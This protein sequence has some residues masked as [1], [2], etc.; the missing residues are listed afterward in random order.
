MKLVGLKI[1]MIACL[2]LSNLVQAQQDKGWLGQKFPP[3]KCLKIQVGE[4]EVQRKLCNITYQI[5]LKKSRYEIIG[6]LSFNKKFVPKKPKRVEL[7][8]LFMDNQFVCRKQINI[9]KAVNEI[10]VKF[11]VLADKHPDQQFIR[12][13]YTLYYQ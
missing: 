3:E 5:A 13:Y 9:D 4:Y 7:E 11:T 1:M 10:P 8:I 12:T 2:S 6:N